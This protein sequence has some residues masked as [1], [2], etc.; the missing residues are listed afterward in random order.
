MRGRGFAYGAGSIVNAIA[1]FKGASF[2]LPLKTEVFVEFGEDLK[3]VSGE[4]EGGGNPFLI[5]FCVR[6][7]IKRFGYNGGAFVKIS[8]E[9]PQASGLKS[10]SA[11][12]NATIL[13]CMNAF[14]VEMS[15]VEVARW[16]A[17]I[18]LKAGVSITGAFDDA[19]TSLVGGVVISDNKKGEVLKR[20]EI[21]RE[22][23]ILIPEGKVESGKVDVERCRS[24]APVIEIAFDMAMK[25]R[26]EEAMLIN[27]FPYCSALKLSTEPIIQALREGVRGVTLSGTGPSYVAWGEVR[28]WGKYGRV[29]KSYVNNRGVMKYEES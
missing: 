29:I 26:F 12:V 19:I 18:S 27:G 3:D 15:A 24:I 20:R 16:N 13:A 4:V 22:V 9:I 6:E 23:Q 10:S 2:A 7:W 11:A 28:G 17:E 8:S 25:E 14:G 21:E 5:E 1:T